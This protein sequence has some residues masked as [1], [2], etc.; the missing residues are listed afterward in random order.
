MGRVGRGSRLAPRH[1]MRRLL[2]V[3][4]CVLAGCGQS[5]E[6][7]AFPAPRTTPGIGYTWAFYD[8]PDGGTILETV[9]PQQYLQFSAKQGST[10]TFELT[11]MKSATDHVPDP[12]KQ[13]DGVVLEGT[14]Q[15]GGVVWAP[16]ARAAS[17]DGVLTLTG[18]SGGDDRVH[19]VGIEA[20]PASYDGS[21]L[22]SVEYAFTLACANAS[23]AACA[24]G[25][26][27]GDSCTVSPETCDGPHQRCQAAAT[28]SNAGTCVRTDLA[29]PG[30]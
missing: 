19:V 11:A 15:D 13:L 1:A 6:L 7:P 10:Y 4:F 28:G 9:A 3:G 18:S 22:P 8:T 30:G 16:L 2:V 14:A 12:S 5:S 27:P 24:L 25:G 26:Q 21:T 23:H 29:T 20:A 17:V